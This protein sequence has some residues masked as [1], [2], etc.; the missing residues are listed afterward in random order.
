MVSLHRLTL[1]VEGL[2]FDPSTGDSFMMN[3]SGA[4]ILQALQ[5][6]CSQE[7]IVR[8]LSEEY[9]IPAEDAERDVADFRG[10]LRHLQLV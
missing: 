10:R 3:N 8:M 7:D 5:T 6:G 4:R 9:H 1:P 2:A